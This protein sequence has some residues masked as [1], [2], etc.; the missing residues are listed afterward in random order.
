MLDHPAPFTSGA[1][2]IQVQ[3]LLSKRELFSLVFAAAEVG[4]GHYTNSMTWA[5]KAADELLVELAKEKGPG[6]G[7]LVGGGP[8]GGRSL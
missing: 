3:N 4:R 6:Q 7:P 8:G 2:Q 5:V 1:F